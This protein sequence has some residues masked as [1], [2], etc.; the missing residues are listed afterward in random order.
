MNRTKLVVAAVLLVV[1]AVIASQGFFVVRKVV[2]R[3]TM[4]EF[5]GSEN[6]QIRHRIRD[7]VAAEAARFGVTIEDVRLELK[8]EQ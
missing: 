6:E 4:A 3:R 7:L 1:V 2:G 8:E 5:Q